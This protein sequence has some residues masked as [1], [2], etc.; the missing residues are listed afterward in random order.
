MTSGM[1]AMDVRVLKQRLDEGNMV[2]LDV[3][4]PGEHR[5]L[6]IKGTTLLPLDSIDE[7]A[8]ENL[9]ESINGQEIC[10]IC[11]S[12]RQS[13]FAA[14]KLLD[15]G[16][17]K[18]SILQGGIRSWKDAEFPLIRGKGPISVNR[19]ARLLVG[20]LVIA[21]TVIFWYS[22]RAWW[23]AMPAFLGLGLIFSG[24]TGIR[25]LNRIIRKM[26]WNR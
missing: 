17:E 3:R 1:Q 14:R 23:L 5:K 26:P 9:K 13:A 24:A 22:Q 10:A 21:G 4:T 20:T 25:G 8:I 15:Q 6:H 16:F 2:L 7:K 18:V 12:G 11:V 19:Q